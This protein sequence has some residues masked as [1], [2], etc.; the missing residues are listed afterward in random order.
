MRLFDFERLDV[1]TRLERWFSWGAILFVGLMV[2]CE[3]FSHML[4]ER[5]N[6]L[7]SLPGP[8]RLSNSISW[9]QS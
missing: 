6:E 1:V 2:V 7:Q 9:C 4:A 3:M 8:F 5:K